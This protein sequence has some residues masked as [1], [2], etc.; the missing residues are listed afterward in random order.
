MASNYIGILPVI[1]MSM[2]PL[3]AKQGTEI[4][5]RPGK[6]GFYVWLTGRRGEPFE[7]Q[8]VTDVSNV[9]ASCALIQLYESMAGS[10]QTLTYA[11]QLY[12][13][14]FA[15]LNVRPIP[16]MTRQILLGVGGTSGGLSYGICGAS[17]ELL[18]TEQPAGGF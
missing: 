6:D 17:W 11:N 5:S 9:A 12:P 1:S 2:S 7:I 4:E 8:T 14:Y 10:L 18:E 13:Y 3:G 16:D 15:V